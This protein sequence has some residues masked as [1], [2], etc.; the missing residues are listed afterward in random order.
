MLLLQR[1]ALRYETASVGVGTLLISLTRCQA[2]ILSMWTVLAAGWA[3]YA[4]KWD[5]GASEV[6]L[7]FEPISASGTYPVQIQM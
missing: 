1:S 4:Q 2:A 7:S 6:V 3:K 5:G